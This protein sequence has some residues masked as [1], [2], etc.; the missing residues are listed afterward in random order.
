MI[1]PKIFEL[2]TSGQSVT[3]ELEQNPS[4]A[5]VHASKKL[6]GVDIQEDVLGE[7]ES[8]FVKKHE[9]DDANALEQAYECGN[10][11]Q[12]R[13]SELFLKA[14]YESRSVAVTESNSN[15]DVPRCPTHSAQEPSARRMLSVQTHRTG[16]LSSDCHLH[17]P[18]HLQTH[19]QRHCTSRTRSLPSDELLDAF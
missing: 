17:H 9:D 7:K 1:P 10:F 12:T 5:P 8:K 15:A 14:R 18:G 3:S 6:F 16:K 13:P 11:G 4:E 19:V 2:C